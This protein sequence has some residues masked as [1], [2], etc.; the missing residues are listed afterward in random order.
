MLM[1]I[2]VGT[3]F[4]LLYMILSIED[5]FYTVFN[6]SYYK[7]EGS[8]RSAL[9]NGITFYS[10]FSFLFSFI[11]M[12]GHSFLM[13]SVP[14]SF[15]L[16]LIVVASFIL[17]TPFLIIGYN[18]F[19]RLEEYRLSNEGMETQTDTFTL[20]L[21]HRKRIFQAI[22]VILISSLVVFISW[23]V[24]TTNDDINIT[25]IAWKILLRCINNNV[26][27]SVCVSIPSLLNLYSSNR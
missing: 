23:T 6:A 15:F 10:I 8:V 24:K 9:R 19:Q 17:I 16:W 18:S 3:I 25:I 13:G 27:V 21:K 4:G 7:K 14:I 26:K 11:C 5:G 2:I 12:I 22:I 1:L 20:L